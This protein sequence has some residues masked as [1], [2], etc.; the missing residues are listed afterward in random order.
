MP[1]TQDDLKAAFAGESQANRKY[2]F[3]AEKAEKDGFTQVARL[4]RAIAEAE[5]VHAR[6]HLQALNGIGDTTKNLQEAISGEFYEFSK[7]Y[8]EF[9]KQAQADNDKR[10]QLS[11]NYANQVEQIHHGL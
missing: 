5:T 7:M 10:A 11:F 4:F 6:N 9:I 8:P 1:N 3:W 2:L